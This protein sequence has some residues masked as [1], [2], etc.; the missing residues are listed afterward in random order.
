MTLLKTEENQIKPA[1]A[2]LAWLHSHVETCISIFFFLSFFQYN[3][4]VSRNNWFQMIQ[5][6]PIKIPIQS[7]LDPTINNI[8]ETFPRKTFRARNL[9]QN[10]K[11]ALI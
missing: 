5:S 6:A 4:N 9:R 1:L 2:C 10:L 7:E 3:S 8:I 11:I